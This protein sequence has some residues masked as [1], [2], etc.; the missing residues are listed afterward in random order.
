MIRVLIPRTR[1]FDAPSDV[2]PVP[3]FV[4]GLEITI[5]DLQGFLQ[6]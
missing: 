3:E 1:Y 5:A 4:R 6:D 2:L